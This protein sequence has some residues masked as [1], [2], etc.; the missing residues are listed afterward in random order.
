MQ[1]N[2]C[3]GHNKNCSRNVQYCL[4]N[5]MENLKRNTYRELEEAFQNILNKHYQ[6]KNVKTSQ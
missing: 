4:K 2:V 1:E 6:N 5:K 3:I